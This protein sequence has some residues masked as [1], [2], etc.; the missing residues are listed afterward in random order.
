[1][2]ALVTGASGFLGRSVVRALAQ[3]GFDVRV[4][5]RSAIDPA[6]LGWPEG[7]EPFQADLRVAP[8]L[9][10]AFDGVDVLVHLAASVQGDEMAQF[11]TTVCG[12]ERL[13][14]AMRQT[15]VSRL[16]LVSSYSVYDWSEIRAEH[17][18]RAPLEADLY[19]RDGYAIAKV[20]QERV[21]R[22]MSEES[23]WDLRVVRPAAIWGREAPRFARLGAS[24]GPVLLLFGTDPL[25]ITHVDN[26]ADA[27]AEVARNDA[28][29]GG[30]FN[31]VDEHGISSWRYAGDLAARGGEGWI[32]IPLPYGL[33]HAAT[34]LVAWTARALLGPTAKLPSVLTPCRFEARFKPVRSRAA[35]LRRLGWSPPF[36]YA[37]CLDRTFGPATR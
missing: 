18:E 11:V 28:A 17:D 37:E 14:E 1:M 8:D 35:E 19:G 9:A 13:L 33:C 36:S 2:R 4:L 15:N 25:L 26:C 20:W 3:R 6:A 30:T 29:K 32:R 10:R 27:I 7:I 22:R 24:L 16:V 5:V 34:R 31:V 12:T 21:T 23:G